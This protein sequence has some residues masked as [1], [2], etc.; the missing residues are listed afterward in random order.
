MIYFHLALAMIN[1]MLSGTKGPIF[2]IIVQLSVFV[3]VQYYAKKGRYNLNKR[4]LI[5]NYTHR[6]NSDVFIEYCGAQIKNFDT[7]VGTLN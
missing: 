7:L 3:F 2:A 4:M 5:K 1:G 6:T